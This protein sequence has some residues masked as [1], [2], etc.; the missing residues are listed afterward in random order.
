MKGGTLLVVDDALAVDNV[1][2]VGDASGGCGHRHCLCGPLGPLHIAVGAECWPQ[3]VASWHGKGRSDVGVVVDG[4]KLDATVWLKACHGAC[5][6][7]IN[8]SIKQRQY[9]TNGLL[10]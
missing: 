3:W 1:L 9:V 6:Q 5:P 4:R 2:G 7:T 8:D 10:L